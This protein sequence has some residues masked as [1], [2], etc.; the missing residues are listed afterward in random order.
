M[1]RSFSGAQCPL[2]SIVDDDASMRVSLQRLIRSFGFRTRGFASAQQF[3]ESGELKQTG[4]LVLDIRMPHMNGLELQRYLS[5]VVHELPIIFVTGH[6][7][8]EDHRQAM[9][10]GAVQFLRKPVSSQALMAAIPLD[11]WRAHRNPSYNPPPLN[12]PDPAARNDLKPDHD[13]EISDI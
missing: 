6:V 7:S 5:Q 2:V 12:H 8:E 9:Q 1:R 4:C 3:L 10:A 13:P 11:L